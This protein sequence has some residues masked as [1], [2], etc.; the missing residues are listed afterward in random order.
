[1]GARGHGGTGA[2]GHGQWEQNKGKQ[3]DRQFL[4]TWG[5]GGHWGAL[6]TVAGLDTVTGGQQGQRKG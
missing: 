1:M 4:G 2:W 3:A 5:Q 6:L